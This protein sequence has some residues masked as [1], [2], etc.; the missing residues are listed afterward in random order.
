MESKYKIMK[1]IYS[2]LFLG[3]ILGFT[4]CEIDN[5]DK[6][7]AFFSGQITY[8]DDPIMVG[9]NHVKFQLWQSGFGNEGPIDVHVDQDGSFSAR[10]FSG[11]YRLKLNEGDGPFKANFVNEQLG[12]TILVDLNGD[13]NLNIEVTPYYMVRNPQ[14]SI[15]GN[16]VEASASLE[17]IIT[18]EDAK[19]IEHATLYLNSTMFVS[20]N[21]DENV[22]RG[23]ADISELSNLSMSVDIPGDITQDYI[24]ARI[25]VRISGVE[26]MIFSPVEK[27]TF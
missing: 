7:D 1:T 24:F 11:T 20:N 6:P 10:M 13:T 17:Q 21:N 12:D 2:I 14:F 26:D 19:D 15:S 5:Y 3:L 9:Y 16:T 27:L 22:A 25:G 4:S 18:G 8:Q 23:D